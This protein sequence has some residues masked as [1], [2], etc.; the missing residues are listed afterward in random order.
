ML[1]GEYKLGVDLKG[2]VIL[3]YEVNEIET[4][5]LR[6]GAAENQRLPGLDQHPIEQKL[7]IKICQRL[8]HHVIL[9]GGHAA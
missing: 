1:F 3:V 2:G 9:P 7:G 6:R 5:Q 4:E 8:F